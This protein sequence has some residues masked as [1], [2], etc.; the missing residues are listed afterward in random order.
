MTNIKSMSKGVSH[1]AQCASLWFTRFL[2]SY[3]LVQ[4]CQSHCRRYNCF[5]KPNT[6]LIGWI[7][8]L[9][10][11]KIITYFYHA[12]HSGRLINEM[13]FEEHNANVIRFFRRISCTHIHSL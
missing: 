13:L 3:D 5:A 7:F 12:I 1:I 2:C 9:K 4:M 8:C 11:K 10:Y 6:T